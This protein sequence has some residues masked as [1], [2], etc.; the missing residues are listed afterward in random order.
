MV[1]EI[2]WENLELRADRLDDPAFSPSRNEDGRAM[3]EGEGEGEA[4]SQRIRC[5]GSDLSAHGGMAA[6]PSW[7][8]GQDFILVI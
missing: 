6:A 1:G 2:S 3:G 7:P 4:V 5:A 8:R